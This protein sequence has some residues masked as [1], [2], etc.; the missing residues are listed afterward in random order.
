MSKPKRP[1]DPQIF[2]ITDEERAK[3]S[4]EEIKTLEEVNRDFIKDV[5]MNENDEYSTMPAKKVNFAPGVADDGTLF[6]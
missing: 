6:N 1:F 3:L 2:A 5:I 4:P